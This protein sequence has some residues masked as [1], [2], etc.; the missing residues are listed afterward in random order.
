MKTEDTIHLV[1]RLRGGGARTCLFTNVSDASAM[2]V[3]EWAASAP[4]WRRAAQGL[5]VEGVCNNPAC[6]PRTCHLLTRRLSEAGC[7]S[8]RAACRRR[9]KLPCPA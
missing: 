4:T 2:T 8:T 5:C 6:C 3:C 9:R 1:L 7:S